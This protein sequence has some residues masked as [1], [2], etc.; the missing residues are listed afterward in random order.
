MP[1][2]STAAYTD[3]D[4]L[5]IRRAIAR[6]ERSVQFADRSVTYRSTEELIAAESRISRALSSTATTRRRKQTRAYSSKGF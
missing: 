5:A 1:D 3:A 6:G 4:L 2:A